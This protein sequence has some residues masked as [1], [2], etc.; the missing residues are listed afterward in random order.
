MSEGRWVDQADVVLVGAGIMSATLAA[1]MHELQPDACI[2]VIERLEEVALES[3]LATNNA[4]TGHAAN[5]EL[6]Y[7]PEQAD[8]SVE[9]SKAFKINESFEISLQ[10]WSHLVEKGLLPEPGAFLSP[11]PHLSF[12]YGADS[13]R[14][15][16][17]RHAALKAHPMFADMAYSEDVAQLREWIP[18]MMEGREPGQPIA[19]TRVG[20]GTDVDFGRLAG[21]LFGGLG[22]GGDFGILTRHHVHGLH[23][24]ADGRWALQ[25]RD[26][27]SGQMRVMRARFVFLGAGGGALPLLLKS[28][29]PEAAGYGG[30][31]VSGQWLVCTNPGVIA[32]HD[33]KVYGK[34][35]VGAPP[36]SVPH[37]DTR[38]VEGRP[39]LLFGP[40]AGFTTK[41]LKRGSFLDLPL[42][43]R[44][45]NL[46]PMMQA[47][48]KNLDLTRYLIGQV[49]QSMDD[50]L[51]ALQEFVP[52]AR[53]QDWKLD[54][55]GQR[56][57]IIKRD[58]KTGQGKLEFGTEVVASADGSLAAL[59]GASPGA[60]TAVATMLEMLIRCFPEKARSEAWQATIARMVP[61]YGHT[62]VDDPE[63]LGRVR[64]RTTAVLGLRA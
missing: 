5:C 9:T 52:S 4:G 6:N 28:G 36:M 41:F 49:F 48:W 37:L 55:A 43:L 22:Q 42:S 3:S 23:Q 32:R 60:S 12:V 11:V 39:A 16:R 13:V 27:A 8:G 51:K 14:F 35:S 20:R 24:E 2:R 40:Y 50:R 61:S 45:H 63:L 58:P 33:A 46:L 18:L 53:A 47:G 31:P 44:G 10:F 7:T 26:L 34:A 57:Q 25:V 59:L 64:A 54:I 19:A 30:F 17:T 62:L 29:I 1:L 38:M 15:L 56:V 21:Q